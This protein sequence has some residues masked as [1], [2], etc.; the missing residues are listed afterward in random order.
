MSNV[1]PLRDRKPAKPAASDHLA[2]VFAQFPLEVVDAAGVYLHTP[3]GR[4][5][6]DLYGGHAVAALGYGHPRWTEAL[7]SQAH[8]LCFQSNAV[9]LDVRRRAA[10]KLARFCGLGLDTV[11][12]INSGAEANENALKLA[13]KITGGNEI[14]AIEGSFHGRTAAAGAVTWGA[15]KKWYG[16]PEKPFDV[17]FIKPTDIDRLSSLINNDTAAVI[18]EPVQGVAGAVDLSK[19]FLAAL[20]TRCSENGSILIFDEVQCGVGRTGYPFAAN[21][22][23][24]TPDII[25]TAKALG[26][27]FPVSAMLVADHV[28][29]YLQVDSLGT[30]F[31]GGPMACAIVEAV[32]DIIESENLLENVR[33][34]SEQI[35]KTCVVGPVTG[36]QGAGLLLGL[37]T[38]RPAKEIQAELLK[39]DILTGTSGDPHVLRILAPFVLGSEHVEQ[40][41]QALERL[42][43]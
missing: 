40:L 37:R 28:A 22:Y 16:F 11:F 14:I 35:R 25:T 34:R 32:I 10:T 8:M 21:M 12:F 7:T 23:G 6:L 27:G 20:R 31:G 39:L 36:T 43:K 30:T 33:Q 3:D 26:A 38:S 18:V 5:V 29:A 19:E 24:I 2:P 4:K 1:I 15:D 17:K 13:C 41:R 9:P 42:P